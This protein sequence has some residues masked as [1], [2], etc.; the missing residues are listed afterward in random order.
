MDKAPVELS[1]HGVGELHP[2]NPWPVVFLRVNGWPIDWFPC[3]L[4]RQRIKW[5]PKWFPLNARFDSSLDAQAQC[6]R[7]LRERGEKMAQELR[8]RGKP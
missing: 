3:G 2:F 1:I 4:V 5:L 6:L 8:G 7:Q